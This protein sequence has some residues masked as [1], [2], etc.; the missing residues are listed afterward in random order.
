MKKTIIIILFLLS[1]L[2]S[3]KADDKN[4]KCISTKGISEKIKCVKGKYENFR[5][6]VPK[7]GIETFKKINKNEN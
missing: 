1:L 5:D 3:V 4:K 6:T 2:F 7:T